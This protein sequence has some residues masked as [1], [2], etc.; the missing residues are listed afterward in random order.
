MNASRG[1]EGGGRGSIGENGE[2]SQGGENHNQMN[3]SRR[4]TKGL[5][6][7]LNEA[8]QKLVKGLRNI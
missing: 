3:P 6:R 7:T 8:P 2:E 5:E 4:K 1:E